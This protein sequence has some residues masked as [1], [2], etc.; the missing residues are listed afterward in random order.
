MNRLLSLSVA[1][2]TASWLLAVAANSGRAGD[3]QVSQVSDY[4]FQA[5]SG[6]GLEFKEPWRIGNQ[7]F[8]RSTSSIGSEIYRTDGNS[9]T[10]YDLNPGPGPDSVPTWFHIWRN[11]LYFNAFS[12]AL[13]WELYSTSGDT[14]TLVA[15]IVPGPVSSSAGHGAGYAEL[16]DHLYFFAGAQ[17]N[18]GLYRTSGIGAEFVAPSSNDA[19]HI[20]NLINGSLIF[21]GNGANGE[22]FYRTDG[23]TVSQL[24][25]VN[26]GP[27]GSNPQ[28]LYE[29]AGNLYFH[30]TGPHG[31]ELFKTDGNSVTELD[32]NP[33]P[34]SSNPH[35]R[36]VFKNE[37]YFSAS[38]N[39]GYEMFKTD[40]ASVSEVDINPGPA[41]SLAL[42]GYSAVL[43]DRLYFAATG[44]HGTELFNTDG[45]II[46]EFDVNPGAASSKPLFFKT[47]SDALYFNAEGPQ[48][49]ELYKVQ[50]DNISLIDLNPGTASSNP[51]TS[52]ATEVN[53]SVYLVANGTSGVELFRV[54]G[55][56]ATGFDIYPGPRGS[57][58]QSFVEFNGD[59]FFSA[60]GPEGRAVYRIHGSTIEEVFNP[61]P[62]TPAV[63]GVDARITGL[64]PFENSLLFIGESSK[65]A[66][67]YRITA[68]PEPT[69][70]LP[71]LL[72]VFAMP[73]R[74]RNDP[75][76][77]TNR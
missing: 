18:Y 23:Q 7:L 65:G 77:A 63:T 54:D 2:F 17:G 56:T 66:H 1:A 34:A 51:S 11:T 6:G 61:E 45:N 15:D 28:S 43:G 8:F 22:E 67:L 13:G 5:S 10:E 64:V 40:G 3:Y 35:G 39:N 24:A 16:G 68:V 25:D 50:G 71:L 74:Q 55:T 53:G 41:N 19:P 75:N 14:P 57:S 73:S 38:R 60:M 58:P 21:V 12:N 48:G 59:L 44:P 27:A 42:V 4:T 31:T 49:K 9:V 32:I 47:T 29:F 52:I 70:L 30:A 26:P 20:F 37:L 76:S 72:V 46:K 69:S 36:V 62:H 33:G